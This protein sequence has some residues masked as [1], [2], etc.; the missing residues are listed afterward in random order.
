MGGRKMIFW[1]NQ[2]ILKSQ[3]RS[4]QADKSEELSA[5]GSTRSQANER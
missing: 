4:Q 5:G 2:R 1:N 3:Q